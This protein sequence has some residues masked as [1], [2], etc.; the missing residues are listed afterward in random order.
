MILKN[1]ENMFL[2][3]EKLDFKMNELNLAQYYFTDYR[4]G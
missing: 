1:L 4:T 2:N 3:C